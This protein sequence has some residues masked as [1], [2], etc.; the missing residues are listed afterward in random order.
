MKIEYF[1][2]GA[3]AE[4]SEE[5]VKNC[6]KYDS[7]IFRD[8][9]LNRLDEK[10]RREVI[11]KKLVLLAVADN[12]NAQCMMWGRWDPSHVLKAIVKRTE[13][14]G[15]L[16]TTGLTEGKVNKEV[17]ITLTDSY[18]RGMIRYYADLLDYYYQY[19]GNPAKSKAEKELHLFGGTHN[20]SELK[21]YVPDDIQGARIYEVDG[22]YYI[23]GR[24]D[25]PEKMEKYI[26][27]EYFVKHYKRYADSNETKKLLI[28]MMG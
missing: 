6:I 13:E 18:I 24:S 22:R 21:E 5:E 14:N 28:R 3:K 17:R 16:Y 8:D 2:R 15:Y 26:T 7:I 20:V 25:A 11:R 23:L 4:L 1:D 10:E 12:M 19:S 9:N 27:E